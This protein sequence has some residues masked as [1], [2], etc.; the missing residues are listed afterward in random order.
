MPTSF[1]QKYLKVSAVIIGSF[2]P[3]FCLGTLDATSELARWSLDLLKWPL[4]G[5][6]QVD[7]P[8]TRFLLALTGG[9]L[10]GW[11]V[12]VWCL[13]NDIY[14]AAPAAVQ[15]AHLTS[16]VAWFCLDSVGSMMSGTPSNVFFNVIVLMAVVGPFWWPD[17]AAMTG[18]ARSLSD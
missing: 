10:M 1:H 4:D 13:S 5:V 14:N 15:R 17:R 12:L 18:A 11:G 3:I 8:T 9:F 6:E 2:G 16:V 7:A